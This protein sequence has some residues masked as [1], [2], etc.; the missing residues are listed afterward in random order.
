MC[1]K[2]FKTQPE[3]RYH[4]NKIHFQ[5]QYKCNQCPSI[6][7]HP[8]ILREHIKIHIGKKSYVCE[9]CATKLLLVFFLIISHLIV[10][11]FTFL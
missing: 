3:L 1:E 8:K 2:A 5:K 4:I 11:I 6:F 7:A 9:V 10:F